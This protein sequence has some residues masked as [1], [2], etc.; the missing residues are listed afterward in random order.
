MAMR[1]PMTPAAAAAMKPHCQ[2]A[3]ATMKPVA[4][5][6]SA[7]PKEG[8]ELKMLYIVP[9]LFSGNQRDRL[10]VPGGAPIDWTHPFTPHRRANSTSITMEAMPSVPCR[11]PSTP[12]IRLMTAETPRPQA[13]K[14]R[15]L[16]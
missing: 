9:R 1:V 5:I 15:M 11:S 7:L 2:P 6:V 14:R 16:Q 3:M 10:M 4:I 12:R 8:V 13:M